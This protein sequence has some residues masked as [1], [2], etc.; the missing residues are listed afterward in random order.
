[1]AARVRGGRLPLAKT[2]SRPSVVRLHFGGCIDG[3]EMNEPLHTHN[4]LSRP[5]FGSICCQSPTPDWFD[6][7]G[8]PAEC[9]RA[10]ARPAGSR[11]ASYQG[12]PRPRSKRDPP[13][14]RPGRDRQA[15]PRWYS[16]TPPQLST[17]SEKVPTN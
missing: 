11:L 15:S 4:R 14:N 12:R 17:S 9:C 16:F 7:Q 2:R 10:G 1:M 6:C 5:H 8:Q 13:P 3:L